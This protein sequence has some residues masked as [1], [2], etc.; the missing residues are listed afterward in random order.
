MGGRR[1]GGG[2]YRHG[3]HREGPILD[4]SLPSVLLPRPFEGFLA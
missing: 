4:H 1:A 3:P 2:L